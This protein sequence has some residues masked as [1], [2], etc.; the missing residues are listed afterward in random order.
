MALLEGEAGYTCVGKMWGISSKE[1][2]IYNFMFSTVYQGCYNICMKQYVPNHREI[3]YKPTSFIHFIKKYLGN[4]CLVCCISVCGYKMMEVRGNFR[5]RQ[6]QWCRYF[7][8]HPLLSYSPQYEQKRLL[9][10]IFVAQ[11]GFFFMRIGFY[12]ESHLHVTVHIL[13]MII[14]RNNKGLLLV[15][16]WWM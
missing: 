16:Y 1:K 9:F 13:R 3:A 6:S 4:N 15:K 14:Q 11:L 12:V 7:S 8:S 2:K 10:L 5:N